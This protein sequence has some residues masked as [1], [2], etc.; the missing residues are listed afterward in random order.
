MAASN[1]TFAKVQ[2]SRAL[3]AATPV[4][5]V[6]LG[7]SGCTSC[8]APRRSVRVQAMAVSDR[9]MV[10]QFGD[11]AFAKEVA[12]SFPE[13]GIAT[14]E[15]ARVLFST[16]GYVYL[17]VRPALEY[18][19]AGKVRGSVNI[20]LMNSKKVFKDGKV[21][22]E[23]TS[24]PDFIKTVRKRYPDLNAKL[25]VGCSDGK[26][27]S[28]D[29][30]EALDAEGYVNLVGLKGG[31]YAWFKVFDNKLARRNLVKAPAAKK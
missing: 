31:Y 16:L 27:Y 10:R 18:E 7:C 1:M 13:K 24:N 20:P 2:S 30:L 4:G 23:K 14:V 8:V 15:E 11:A 5:K 29:A 12:D 17:D 9:P 25:M 6:H 21:S 26:A 22:F 19:D 3:K 28:I